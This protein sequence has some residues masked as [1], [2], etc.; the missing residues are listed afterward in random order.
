MLEVSGPLKKSPSN[1]TKDIW[2]E[3]QGEEDSV[4]D[5]EPPSGKDGS[6]PHRGIVKTSRNVLGRDD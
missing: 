1:C 6:F 5:Q 2:A 4:L 3:H